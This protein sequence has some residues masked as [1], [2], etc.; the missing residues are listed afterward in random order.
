MIPKVKSKETL[1]FPPVY[2]K[3]WKSVEETVRWSIEDIVKFIFNPNISR[4]YYE[5]AVNFLNFTLDNFPFGIKGK[6]IAKWIKENNISKAT[7]YNRVLPKLISFGLFQRKRV[8]GEKGRVM[9]LI[10]SKTFSLHLK[11][12]AKEW[13]S[14]IDTKKAEKK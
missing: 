12:I 1:W 11:K 2:S 6:E 9:I 14:I 13:E 5:I 4:K 3:E 10:P 7:F 8:H